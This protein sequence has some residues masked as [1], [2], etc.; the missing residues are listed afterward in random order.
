MF[1]RVISGAVTGVESCRVDVEVDLASGLPL[2]E[3]VGLPDSAVKESRERIRAAIRNA[4]FSFPVK[5][6]TVNLA[7]ADIRKSGPAFDL[8]MAVGILMCMGIIKA[9][10]AEGAFF[11]GELSLDGALRPVSGIL[12]MVMEAKAGG[13]SAF[14]VGADN[15]AEAALV[16]GATVYPVRSIGELVKHFSGTPIEPLNVDIRKY[17]QDDGSTYDVDFADVAGQ[18]YVKRALEIA[19]AGYHNALMIGPPGAGKTML[20]RRM[21]TILPDLSLEES[22]EIT[23]IYSISGLIGNEKNIL[24]V[25]RPFRTP[26]HT[27]S[28]ISLTGGGRVPMPGEI[29]LAHN[30]VLFLDE[31]PEF[32]KK[33][34]ETLRQPLEDGQIT[35]ARTG[36]VS[37]YPSVF[38]LLA[39]MNPCPCGYMGTKRCNCSESE[40]ARY[41]EKISGP[42]LDRIDIQV[43]AIPVEYKDLQITRKPAESSATIK[44]RVENARKRQQKRFQADA[45]GIHFN[46]KMPA[47]L[48]KKHCKL[49]NEAQDLLKNVF[50]TMSLSARAYHK[51]LKIAR[52]I[53]DLSDT[54]NITAAH[55]AEAI[56]YRGLDRKYW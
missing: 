13:A 46:A 50:D 43:E 36:G 40:I 16:E 28:Y 22:M 23:K 39:A 19:A 10:A 48:I 1:V 21:P 7:P 14:F 8:P 17:F 11:A 9:S 20:A 30:G 49:G 12:P 33:A 38:L 34:L 2:F 3:I 15:A 45:K 25:Q 41:L 53:A 52:T 27:A 35:I 51:I 47:A 4:G 37:T 29:S 5:R 26:H 18:V 44:E 24:M 31:L 55:V 42:L 32:Q 56:S 54:E 6:I